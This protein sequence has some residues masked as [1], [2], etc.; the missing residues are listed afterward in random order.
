[1]KRI[2]SVLV[3]ALGLAASPA[4]AQDF[5]R[6]PVRIVVPFPPGTAADAI[7][8][9]VSEDLAAS[10][11]QP[12]TV[13]HRS[14]ATGLVGVGYLAHAPA[15]G[16][17]IGVGNEAT[18]VTMPLLK[19]KVA[20]DPL[21]DFT[22]LTLAVRT[23][24]AIAVNPSVLPVRSVPELIEAAKTRPDGVRYGA[25]GDGSPQ[26]LIGELLKQRT[27]GRF[28][29][30]PYA[31]SAAAVEDA[32]AGRLPMVISTLATLAPHQDKLRIV[33]IADATRLPALPGV[34]AIAETVPGF[35]VTGWSGFFAPADL[36]PPVAQKLST[37]LVA[38]LRQPVVMEALRARSLEPASSSPEEL[39]QLVR[40]GL[41]H[42]AP[43]IAKAG[44]RQPD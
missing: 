20:Y 17:T 9:A 14:G 1:M 25:L 16:Y 23:T 15:D 44:L 28:E 37:A 12:V 27:G 42:W 31:G 19:K 2:L 24:M 36:P 3:F 7:A 21:K 18:H 32:I 11:G 26:H 41:A 13:E 30:V 39:R 22:P 6:Q 34:A 43:V 35:V 8:H 10:L 29:H 40:S 5:P 4:Q 33:A 38:V